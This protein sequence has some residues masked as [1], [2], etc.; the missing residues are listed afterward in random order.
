VRAALW[1]AAAIGLLTCASIAQAEPGSLKLATWNLE[2]LMTT[3]EFDRLA[4]DCAPE[5]ARAEGRAI[6]CNIV[7]PNGPSKRRGPE[8][9]GRLRVYARHLDADVIALQEVDG[10]DAARLVF[11]G[12]EFCFT[13]RV[14]VQNVGFA[15]RRGIPLR[16]GDYP[17]LGLPESGVR[18]GADLILFPGT[19]RQ[20]R[21]LAVHLKS[22]CHQQ[23][24]TNRREECQVLADQVPVL[25]RWIQA[26]V[27]EGIAFGVMGDFNRR[28]SLERP[29]ARDPRGRLVSI[30]P[31][32]S[33]VGRQQPDLLNVTAGQPYI[34]CSATDRFH[35]YIDHIVLGG[36][37]VSRMV[38]DSFERTTYADDDMREFKLS[39]HCPVAVR[40]TLE[41]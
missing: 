8:D 23:V 41:P 30:W 1:L 28:F 18:W 39:D 11:P 21:L 40:V 24:L 20:I 25:K 26:R 38:P 27:R 19:S 31:E 9:F 17:A 12:Y 16:C 7:E 3:E 36:A 37:L 33:E 5:L 10:P 4:Q 14:H 22:G 13:R 29:Y 6:P 2:W 32:I 35:S 34:G 15:V